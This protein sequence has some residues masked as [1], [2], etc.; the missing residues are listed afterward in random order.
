M[1]ELEKQDSLTLKEI[2]MKV[3]NYSV[4]AEKTLNIPRDENKRELVEESVLELKQ[5]KQFE[6][7]DLII[8]GRILNV[9]QPKKTFWGGTFSRKLARKLDHGEDSHRKY[10]EAIR[11]FDGDFKVSKDDIWHGLSHKGESLTRKYLGPRGNYSF[12]YAVLRAIREGQDTKEKL[13]QHFKYFFGPETFMT[14]P[15]IRHQN[16]NCI[17]VIARFHPLSC[18]I[19]RCMHVA[20]KHQE[21]VGIILQSI[22]N[23]GSLG[24]KCIIGIEN[25]VTD[26][27][28]LAVCIRFQQGISPIQH[29]CCGIILQIDKDKVYPRGTE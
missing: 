20:A 18:T 8:K 12:K 15:S 27:D 1:T 19:R 28:S 3:E 23:G 29:C 26:D 2:Q 10:L 21:Q 25:T 11:D 14:L 16:I 5:K 17:P 13:A 24:G 4:I 22:E 6:D 9:Y 7:I